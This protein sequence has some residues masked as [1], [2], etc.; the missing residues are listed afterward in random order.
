[1]PRVTVE[2]VRKIIDTDI[3]DN[4]IQAFI[5]T[6]NSLV[7]SVL[8]NQGISEELLIEIEKWLSAHFVSIKD[9]RLRQ[10]R[11]GEVT[12]TYY[13]RG[14]E[15]LNHTPYGQQV[16]LLDYTGSFANLGKR[17]ASFNVVKEKW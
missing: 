7:D 12:E 17:K 15:G 11:I 6:A 16:L 3:T 9:P 8:P 1:M 2:E 5:A 10:L 13:G 14:G 4:E